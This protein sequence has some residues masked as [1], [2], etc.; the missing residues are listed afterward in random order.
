M[1]GTSM[2]IAILIVNCM[3]LAVVLLTFD[4]LVGGIL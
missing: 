3:T 4:V 1:G 2:R